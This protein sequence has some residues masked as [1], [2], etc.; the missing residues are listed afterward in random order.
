LNTRLLD[1][2]HHSYH[3]KG[4]VKCHV[5]ASTRNQAFNSLLFLFRHALKRDFGE[6]RDVPRAKKSLYVPVVLSREEID[7]IIQH[8]YHPY[9]LIAKVLFGCGISTSMREY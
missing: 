7:A 2:C 1:H 9:S 3:S 8:L 4:S 5:A 6:L